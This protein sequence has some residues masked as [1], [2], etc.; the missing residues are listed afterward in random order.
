MTMPLVVP[1]LYDFLILPSL[2]LFYQW[3]VSSS[4]HSRLIEA[5]YMA[6]F[7]ALMVISLYGVI[8][9]LKG[10]RVAAVAGGFVISAYPLVAWL[11]H[12]FFS[13]SLPWS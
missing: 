9:L 5:A 10:G 11:S 7:S 12:T 6:F 3:S 13:I 8:R 4:G 2:Y 1:V